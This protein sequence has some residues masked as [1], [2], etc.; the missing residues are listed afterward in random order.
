MK[1]IA[2]GINRNF[3]RNILPSP[4][5]E[6]DFVMAAIAYGSDFIDKES[7]LIGHCVKNRYRLDLWMRCDETVP[8][9]P[10]MLK[11]IL[12]HHK[13]N[14][15]CNLVPG[16]L[17]S[18]L[19]WWKGY[20]AYIGSANLTERSWLTNIE[21]GVFLSESELQC[22]GMQSE[23]EDFFDRLTSEKACFPLSMEII[24]KLEKID[25]QTNKQKSNSGIL[26]SDLPKW[27]GLHFI[28]N[29]KVRTQAEEF[30][31]E[32]QETL[33]HL[34][35]IGDQLIEYRPEWI[36]P[37]TPIEWQTDQFLHAYYY[38]K[39]RDGKLKP[40][41]DFYARNK[42]DPNS[43]LI[44]ELLW[45]KNQPS[46][47][48]HEDVTLY[49]YAPYIQSSLSKDNLLKLN[50]D[51]FTKVCEYTHATKDHLV[52]MELSI[53]GITDVKSLSTQERVPV[54]AAWLMKQK[55]PRGMN[56]LELI[57]YVLYGGKDADLWERLYKVHKD[58]EFNIPHYGL[59][60]M[61]EVVGWARP[62]ISPPRNG[63]TS[64]ALRALGYSVKIY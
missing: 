51:S 50:V 14:I 20:G 23:L 45:W 38:N 17:H 3:F 18:K 36:N 22:D 48:T 16:H 40:F 1:F 10:S 56:I 27:G 44:D 46:A 19:I 54:Y 11:R 13:D 29:N 62:A 35:K 28:E 60:S 42:S 15:F 53:F 5:D 4:N 9:K 12:H 21:C 34:R 59:N 8:V 33:T 57:N 49:N 2:N 24:E 41:E 43:A 55:T 47:P 31:S 63:R 6:V 30:R 39:V 58:P 37:E 64:K 61:A 32:W 52:K 25:I 7:D 26:K